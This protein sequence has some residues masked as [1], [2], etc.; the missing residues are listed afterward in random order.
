[1]FRAVGMR[2]PWAGVRISSGPPHVRFDAT[3]GPPAGS[4]PFRLAH[5][6]AS[7]AGMRFRAMAITPGDGNSAQQGR[8]VREDR[9]RARK[10]SDSQSEPSPGES[11]E[12]KGVDGEAQHEGIVEGTRKKT[13]S[14]GS[15]KIL[16]PGSWNWVREGGTKLG[17]GHFRNQAGRSSELNFESGF[18]AGCPGLSV[19]KVNKIR[20]LLNP[21]GEL[22][23]A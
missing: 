19:A 2:E 22:K 16:L 21:G 14:T 11:A 1:M 9:E 18:G 6:H 5:S 10:E 15:S 8:S 20:S 4:I 3:D 12:R 23:M 17:A 7:T 13:D